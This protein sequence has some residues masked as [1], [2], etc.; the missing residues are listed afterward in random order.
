MPA[1]RGNVQQTYWLIEQTAFRIDSDQCDPAGTYPN[2]VYGYGRIDAY[3]AVSMALSANW[4]ISWLSVTPAQG[5]VAPD[6]GIT[7]T[8]TFDTTGLDAEQCYTGTLKLEFND[9]YVHEVLMPV[10]LCVASLPS[11]HR[12]YLPIIVKEYAAP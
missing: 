8:L 6:D 1:L 9:P 12:I 3:E 4:D 5:V 11:L 7:L 10:E 2:N